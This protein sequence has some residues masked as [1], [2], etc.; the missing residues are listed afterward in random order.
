MVITDESIFR[1]FSWNRNFPHHYQCVKKF[2]EG[3][4]EIAVSDKLWRGSGH[5][6][7]PGCVEGMNH[8]IR[9]CIIFRTKITL[10]IL[11]LFDSAVI[12]PIHNAIHNMAVQVIPARIPRSI[13]NFN[14]NIILITVD[15][16]VY[17]VR[18]RFKQF[19]ILFTGF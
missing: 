14:F 7:M 6:L 9:Y 17:C 4:G 5:S 15:G 19:L 18:N 10:L 16:I 3:N 2:F 8:L 13:S 11:L 1:D 12:N